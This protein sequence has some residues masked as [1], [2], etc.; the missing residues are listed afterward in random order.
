MRCHA[1]VGKGSAKQHYDHI[2]A[3]LCERLRTPTMDTVYRNELDC[4]VHASNG[5]FGCFAQRVSARYVTG[6]VGFQAARALD[7]A[8]WIQAANRS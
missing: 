1:D 8:R 2:I 7:L 5:S 6:D 4:R 3:A